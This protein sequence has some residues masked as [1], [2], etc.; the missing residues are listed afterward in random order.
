MPANL[1]VPTM[2]HPLWTPDKD[3][4]RQTTLAAFSFWMSSHT[5]KALHAYDDLHRYS[6]DDPAAF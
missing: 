5:G 3:R 6:I 2:T 4:I 1:R